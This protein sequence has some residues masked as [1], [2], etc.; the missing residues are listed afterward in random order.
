MFSAFVDMPDVKDVHTDVGVIEVHV[1]LGVV[2]VEVV[3]VVVVVDVD[4][5][6]V[7]AVDAVELLV[8]L[9]HAE[10]LKVGV[11]EEVLTEMEVLSEVKVLEDKEE[12]EVDI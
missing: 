6:E 11:V 5:V 12:K 3:V 8:Q 4:G 9:V 7:K 1:K 2:E 10:L